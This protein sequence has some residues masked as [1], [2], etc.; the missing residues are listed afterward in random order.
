M[1]TTYLTI[2]SRFQPYTLSEMLVPYQIYKD[3]YQRQEDLYNT[4]AETAGLIGA[5]LNP[6]LDLDILNNTYNPYMQALSSGAEALA[7]EGLTPGGRKQ[8]QELRRRFGREITPIK[9]ASE[10]RAKA[11]ENWDKMLAQDKTLMTNA[12]PYYKGI[13]AYMNGTSPDTTY[14]SGNELYSRGQNLA[15]AFSKT[16]REV[17][18]DERLA[19]QGQYFRIVSQYGANSAEADAFMQGAIDRIPALAKQVDGILANSGIDAKGFTPA[20]KERAR[21]YIIEGMKAG[22]SGETKVDYLQNRWWDLAAKAS[23]K[24]PESPENPLSVITFTGGVDS[25]KSSSNDRLV[26]M[27]EAILPGAEEGTYTTPEI[28]RRRGQIPFSDEELAEYYKLTDSFES[29]YGRLETRR[30]SDKSGNWTG[31]TY[32]VRV[33]PDGTEISATDPSLG[34]IPAEDQKRYS[35]LRGKIAEYDDYRRD[36]RDFDNLIET[37]KFFAGENASPNEVRDAAIRYALYLRN[38]QSTESVRINASLKDS[39]LNNKVMMD[40]INAVSGE[41]EQG[42]DNSISIVENGISRPLKKSEIEELQ[43]ILSDSTNFTVHFDS[44][45]KDK[46]GVRTP[47]IFTYK[48][49]GKDDAISFTINSDIH[50]DMVREYNAVSDFLTDFEPSSLENAPTLYN[51][52]NTEVLNLS[53]GKKL[54]GGI[55]GLIYYDGSRGEYV[56]AVALRDRS[57]NIRIFSETMT[58]LAQSDRGGYGLGDYIEFAG[59]EFLRTTYGK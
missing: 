14:V 48:G 53:K 34:P 4:Y 40:W 44:T 57:G 58:D 12:N 41:L 17:P 8:L 32:Q 10:A 45:V 24:K 55:Q 31:E 11:R 36:R 13:S 49:T 3:E 46:K 28:E 47:I 15:Q 18:E 37:A 39:A 30:V 27:A 21:Q 6:A 52:S 9:V 25:T 59:E 50:M 54:S 26:A 23:L 5:D 42:K 38:K 43:N 2:G 51:P 19:L 16:V 7:T 22:L 56:K 35:D 20:D 29:L 33:F 1:A